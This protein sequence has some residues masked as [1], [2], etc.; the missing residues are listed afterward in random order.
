[1]SDI[2]EEKPS[3]EAIDRWRVIAVG[4]IQNERGEYLICRKPHNRGVFPGQWALPGGGVELGER[5]EEALRREMREEV[6][7]EICEIRPLLFKDGQ[8][9]KLSPDG[10]RQSIYMIFLVFACRAVSEQVRVGEEFEIYAWVRGEELASYDLN[11]ETRDTFIRLGVISGEPSISPL[12]QAVDAFWE[13]IPPLWQRIRGRIRQTAA[14][15]FGLSVEQFHIL[16]HIR[17]GQDTVSELAEAKNIS[18]AAVSQAVEAMVQ[19]G[20]ICRA[21]DS[22]DRR[23]IRLALTD[24]GDALLDAVFDDTRRWMMQLLSPLSD[25]ELDALAQVLESLRK[26]QAV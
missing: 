11:P 18:R 2:Q 7:L 16:R 21:T 12:R 26:A 5:M 13:T 15:Q 17:R 25:V 19:R 20:L 3:D 4:V 10:S 22:R 14:E 6:G 1:M 24:A 9:P 8:Y 23:H